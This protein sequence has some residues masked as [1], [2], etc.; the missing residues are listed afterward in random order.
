MNT[1]KSLLH[2]LFIL[3]LSSLAYA[4]KAPNFVVIYIDDLGW[5]DTSVPMIQ[6]N[7]D[8]K[9]DFHQTP[10]LEKLAKNGMV[11][12]KGYSPAP[13]C[14]PSRISIQYGMSN[15]RLGY[16]TVHDVLA[17]KR[18]KKKQILKDGVSIAH[19]LKQSNKNYVTAHFGKGIEIAF[20]KKLGYDI[21]DENDIGPNGNF[22]GEKVS[23]K[24]QSELPQDDPKRIY[25][26][27]DASVQF[28]KDQATNKEPFFMMVSHYSAHVPHAASPEIIEKYRKLPRGK[29]LTDMDY[30]DPTKMSR[31]Y[32]ECVWRLQY[33]AMV[34]ET[35]TSLGKIMEALEKTG[36]MDNTYVIFTSDNGGGILPNGS[37]TGGKATLMEGGIRV[38]TVISGPGVKK[39]GYCSIP[40]TQ[41]DLYPTIHDLSGAKNTLPENLDGG[42]LREV[43]KNGNSG[44]IKRNMPGIIFNY[45]YYAGAPVNA[46]I[47]GDYKL[48]QQLNTKQYRLHNITSD[49]G[50]KNNLAETQP[51]KVKELASIMD[52]Y[53]QQ[54]NA[55]QIQDVYVA[56]I[57]ELEG[58]KV[59]DQNNYNNDMKK[60]ENM[61]DDQKALFK[62]R[63]E[64][65]LKDNLSRHDKQ[66]K[67]C[68]TQK[69]NT[70]WIGMLVEN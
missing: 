21:T 70:Q 52:T 18:G 68:L 69:K 1:K 28:I 29:Y 61:N 30:M 48:M 65:R 33:A 19:I 45:P 62:A 67:E 43:L 17:E 10:A 32:R 57:N 40:M 42:S 7:E 25:S 50:E 22:H 27:T 14:T 12:S 58:W 31:G 2:I 9:S 11:F 59:M 63:I 23:L 64:K 26:V 44:T 36:Q 38:P 15:A 16:T 56:R 49:L 51:E 6:D 5:A 47:Q 54:V 24:N 13:T 34:E 55:A 20:M 37:L 66:I 53:L 8:S 60:I 4:K 39:G 3:L 46:I 35:D 41:I